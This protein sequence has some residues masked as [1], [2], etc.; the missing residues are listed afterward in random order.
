MATTKPAAKATAAKAATTNPDDNGV[1]DFKPADL[2]QKL[3]RLGD[4]IA[5]Y[6]RSSNQFRATQ[7][8]FKDVVAELETA[9]V[10]DE[11]TRNALIGPKPV[12]AE[13]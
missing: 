6:A 5:A 8:Y 11:K 7:Q 1:K 9:G 2:T 12:P 4:D 10:I 3:T 13:E